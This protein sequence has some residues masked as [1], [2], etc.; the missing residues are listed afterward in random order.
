[1]A[2]TKTNP[3]EQAQ[4]RGGELEPRGDR[5]TDVQ[6]RAPGF[7]DPLE[8]FTRMSE[9]MD[10]TFDRMW[11]DFGL[12]PRRSWLPRGLFSGRAQQSSWAPRIEAFQKA[13]RFIVRAELPGLKKDDVQV[14]LTQ[15]AVTIRGERREEREEEREGY[16][17][18]EREYGGFSREI[19]CRRASS[20]RARRRRSGTDCSKSACR[21]RQQRRAGDER[22]TSETHPGPIRN[23][24]AT[25]IMRRCGGMVMR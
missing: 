1:M 16:F 6:R 2:E 20:L 18:S 7:G 15:D 4:S 5:H 13:D 12:S 3:A 22:S 10:R 11:R 8:M 14:E 19:P 25:Q 24:R 17:H 21:Q 9:E 23:G